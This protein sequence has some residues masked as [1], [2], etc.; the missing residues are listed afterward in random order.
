MKFPVE[1]SIKSNITYNAVV[2]SCNLSGISV[3]DLADLKDLDILLCDGDNNQRISVH[4]LPIQQTPQGYRIFYRQHPKN[5][6]YR[7]TATDMNGDKFDIE[8]HPDDS[9]V[10]TEEDLSVPI[11][12]APHALYIYIICNLFYRKKEYTYIYRIQRTNRRVEERIYLCVIEDG[13]GGEAVCG[14]PL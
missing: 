10:I 11:S 8:K 14:D 6:A 3:I 9:V 7:I 13:G 2:V 5:S 4:N 12:K 1:S